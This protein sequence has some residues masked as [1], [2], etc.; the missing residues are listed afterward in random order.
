MLFLHD[1]CLSLAPPLVVFL[2]F[3]FLLSKSPHLA[4]YFSLKLPS[5]GSLFFS[6]TL[7]HALFSLPKFSPPWINKPT[8]FLVPYVSL[9]K[10][11]HLTIYFFSLKKT[12]PVFLPSSFLFLLKN[13]IFSSPHQLVFLLKTPLIFCL[14]LLS[15]ILSLM[16]H[17]WTT[18]PM[19]HPPAFYSHIFLSI[20]C[21]VFLSTKLLP[22]PLLTLQQV[23]IPTTTMARWWRHFPRVSTCSSPGNRPS[24]SNNMLPAPPR[25]EKKNLWSKRG[26]RAILLNLGI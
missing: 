22:I 18:P 8:T 25:C 2:S 15:R 13:L 26:L 9:S 12:P 7:P 17:S 3:L 19:A 6:V 10:T 14:V 21:S 11:T 24:H 16:K 1:S 5:P 23:S 4:L 20:H